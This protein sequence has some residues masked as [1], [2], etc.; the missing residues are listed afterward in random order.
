M[1]PGTPG[2]GDG[3]AREWLLV[4]L[5]VV[6]AALI[7]IPGQR[8]R[9]DVTR[10]T[11]W[12]AQTENV[13]NG[14]VYWTALG[15]VTLAWL[16]ICRR[17]AGG[18][19]RV[20]RVLAYA[21]LVHAAALLSPPFLSDDSLFYAATS[22]VLSTFHKSPYLPVCQS[23]PAGDPFL[24]VMKENW[25][26]GISAYFPGF[27]ALAWG[28]GSIAR[29]DLGLHLRLYQA[30]A[31][32]CMIAAGA[33]VARA[34]REPAAREQLD[35]S[36][37]GTR[38]TPALGAALVALNPLSVIEATVNAHND[39]LLALGCAGFV[40]CVL[41]RRPALALFCLVLSLLVKASALLLIAVY[42][43][44]LAL[45]WLRP[46]APRLVRALP[47]L[48]VIGM[49]SAMGAVVAIR[50]LEPEAKMFTAVVGSP[51]D[52][53]D[54]CTRS[55]E[56]LPRVVLR[57]ILHLP[58][59]A[60]AVGLL[61]RV[62]GGLWLFFAAWRSG[63][64]PLAWAATGLL[65]YYMY[66]HGWSQ[67]WYLLSLVPLLPFVDAEIWPAARIVCVSACAYYALVLVGNCF[68]DNIPRAVV[69][70]AEGLVVLVPP[71]IALW[72]PLRRI[73]QPRVIPHA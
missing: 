48:A 20:V 3:P 43:T 14:L 2:R 61:F 46:R 18:R 58:T 59:A 53:Y 10:C 57:W 72:R 69:D 60:W 35:G 9:I 4:A 21:A 1:A 24:D 56:C 13:L 11:A 41:R 27:H 52:P 63:T 65:V 70:L 7:A 26:C 25:R 45:G 49:V 6:G 28:V 34:L 55:I 50:V 67:S 64:R 5:G 62:L 8:Y 15:L 19:I 47:I 71:S 73:L 30:T 44:H 17:A 68:A 33:L 39:A 38:M 22:R 16:G 66:L 40:L 32:L 42:C 23:L 37:F 12:P 31:G 29:D 51:L 54:Y 36:A